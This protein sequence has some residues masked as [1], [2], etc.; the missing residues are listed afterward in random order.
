MIFAAE[1]KRWISVT[2]PPRPSS[3]CWMR[4][5]PRGTGLASGDSGAAKVGIALEP[6]FHHRGFGGPLMLEALRATGRSR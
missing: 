5:P 4:L 6:E 2:A 3:A 1:P